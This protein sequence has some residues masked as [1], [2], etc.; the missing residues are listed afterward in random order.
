MEGPILAA[1]IIAF[2]LEQG[3]DTNFFNEFIHLL[4]SYFH[5]RGGAVPTKGDMNEATRF[6]AALAK[7]NECRTL[8]RPTPANS[9][10][11]TTFAVYTA[12]TSLTLTGDPDNDWMAVRRV[13]ETGTCSRLKDVANDVR[14]VRLLQRGTVLRQSLAQNWRDY[15]KYHDA[16]A[17]TRQSFLQEHF[18]AAHKPES[19]VVVMNMHK[20]KGKQFDEVII[21]EGW[22]KR[23]RGEI[24]ANPDRI[25]TANSQVGSMSHAR[26][27]FRVSITRAKSRTTILTPRD[28]I[29][30]LLTASVC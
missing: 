30:V 4:C 21:F 3:T 29:C 19:G 28:D 24:V 12:A 18:A 16:L 20:A 6:Q 27:N 9:V 23:A 2:L 5:G 17:I 26:Q 8:E 15:G 14:N 7:W 10:L 13:L 11:K 25:V 22:P 1:E